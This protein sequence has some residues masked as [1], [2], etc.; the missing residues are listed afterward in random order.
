MAAMPLLIGPATRP[1]ATSRTLEP[2]GVGR[3][4]QLTATSI[5]ASCGHDLIN[6]NDRRRGNGNSDVVGLKGEGYEFCNCDFGCGC[7]FGI[8]P[9]STDGSCRAFSVRRR[10]R[11]ARR[12]H[13][14]SQLLTSEKLV[15][16]VQYFIHFHGLFE[17]RA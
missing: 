9:N 2:F 4:D 6:E 13:G 10:D 7:N 8:F 5:L 14:F 15:N 12:T 11:V 17:Y 16:H 3:A 1:M